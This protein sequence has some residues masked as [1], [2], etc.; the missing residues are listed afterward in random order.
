MAFFT[1][2]LAGLS[3]ILLSM[4]SWLFQ[5]VY[6]VA[7]FL[8]PAPPAPELPITIVLETSLAH[9]SN[10]NRTSADGEAKGFDGQVEGESVPHIG[11]IVQMLTCS[12]A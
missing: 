11:V 7:C 3:Q 8:E 12:S 4:C 6:F 10:R 5:G 9:A 1:K 2:V